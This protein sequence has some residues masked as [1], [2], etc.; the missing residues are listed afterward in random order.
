MRKLLSANFARL[1]IDKIF[2]LGM[3]FMFGLGIFIVCTK[4]S[5]LIRYQEQEL[6]DDAVLAYVTFI[7]CCSAL[8]CSLFLGTEYSDGTIRNKMIVG[9]TR[10]A[11]Y[12]SNWFISI[13]AAI[14]MAAAF[15]LS[16]S[17]LGSFLLEEPEASVREMIFYMV[18]SLFTITAYASLFNMLSML[19]SK[20][21]AS[22]VICLL[23]FLGLMMLALIIRARL[24]AP[25]FFTPYSF[26]I[27]GIEQMEPT[28]NPHYLQPAARRVHQFFLDVLP[29]GQSIQL[30]G[31]NVVHPY[32]L[33]LYSMVISVVTTA[34]GIFAFRKK[35]LK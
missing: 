25:E 29:Y 11:I 32:F 28:P 19:I 8:F 22:A 24:E 35:N 21:S 23:V 18:I 13:F 7:G 31:W 33:I 10:E 27:N 12:L 26:T 4:Y 15:I 20:K 17:I 30:A 9:H 14:L 3:F 16:Y 6:F 34:V 2:R 5:D 1:R